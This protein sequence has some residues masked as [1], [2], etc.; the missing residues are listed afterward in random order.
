MRHE[1]DRAVEEIA[2]FLG[3]DPPRDR[4]RVI[5]FASARQ[6]RRYLREECPH[7]ANHA[8]VSIRTQSEYTI[9][10]SQRRNREDTFR[11]LRHE[12]T[13]YV[14]TAHYPRL[15]PWINE[16]LAQFFEP[17]PPY[18][19]LHPSCLEAVNRWIAQGGAVDLTRLVALPE[20]VCL[21][22]EDY[23][24]A[25]AVTY[26]LLTRSGQGV[27]QAKHYL[28]AVNSGADAEAQFSRSF[29]HSPGAM[30]HAW[31]RHLRRLEK[32]NR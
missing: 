26:F 32:G 6:L 9:A 12:L 22:P 24:Q 16:G 1:G 14:L 10:L 28:A 27:A 15:P 2:R 25:W 31:R 3:L 19:Q 7:L 4:A 23:A 5:L 8:A 18:P 17:P 20:G 29:G 21:Q 13:H 30:V 11:F